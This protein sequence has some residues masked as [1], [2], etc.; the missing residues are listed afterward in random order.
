M[1]LTD[2]GF[3][4]MERG[5]IRLVDRLAVA[6]Q[7]ASALSSGEQDVGQLV[8]ANAGAGSASGPGER[9]TSHSFLEGPGDENLSADER[10]ARAIALRGLSEARA[11]EFYQARSSFAHAAA[12]D[13]TLDLTS[14][15]AFWQL[16]K[17]AHEAAVGAYTDANRPRDAAE[18]TARINVRFRPRL[19]RA[20]STA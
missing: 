18:L 14:L 6:L 11:G 8:F 20:R 16:A 17:P 19:V 12:L 2:T 13:P 1:L 9:Q 4:E 5:W 10:R 7:R 3:Y 15:P